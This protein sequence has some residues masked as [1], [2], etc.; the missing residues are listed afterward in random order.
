[1]PRTPDP[2]RPPLT[3]AQRQ[4]KRRARVLADI[5]AL[6]ITAHDRGM[7]L[8]AVANATTLREARAIAVEALEKTA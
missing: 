6:R 2:D 7:A 3:E 5:K 1:M 8:L 4:A